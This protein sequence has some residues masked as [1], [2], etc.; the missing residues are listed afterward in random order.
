[1]PNTNFHVGDM[2]VHRTGGQIMVIESI[3]G[4][5]AH[6]T[7]FDYS[8]SDASKRDRGTHDDFLMTDLRLVLR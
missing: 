7:W 1:V 2:V 5:S 6:C 8:P 3:N 4:E